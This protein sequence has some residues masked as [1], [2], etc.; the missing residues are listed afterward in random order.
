M[1]ELLVVAL[2]ACGGSSHPVEPLHAD[3]VP[4]RPGG[5]SISWGDNTF[6]ENGLPAVA[7]GG[8]VVAFAVHDS[9]GGRGYPNL[10]IEIH[11]RT[12]KLLQ[13]IPVMI[14][15]DFE[16]LVV[17]GKPTAELAQRIEHANTE[18][19]RLHAVH[20]FAAMQPLELQ[21]TTDGSDKHLAIGESVDVDW[22]GDHLH[23][24]HH[25]TD[26]PIVTMPV[27]KW[28]VPD[29][30]PCPACEVCDNPAYLANVYRAKLVAS[31][32]LVEIGYHGT[33]TCWEPGHQ[34]HV[35]TW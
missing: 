34:L 25:N 17:D 14:S 20:D 22:G 30:K 16:K 21:A 11:D 29:H 15:N 4:P 5:P 13:T 35:V 31:L 9:D 32:I 24:F 28:L 27:A 10:R 7:A 19:A 3:N 1:R 8:E 12:D 18:L 2:V 6:A 33:D 23:V 26:K